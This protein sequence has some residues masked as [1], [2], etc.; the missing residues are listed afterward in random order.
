MIFLVQFGVNKHLLIFAKTTNCTRPTGS[1][2]FVSLWKNLLISLFIYLFAYLFQ[3]ALEIMWLPIQIVISKY[4]P[5]SAF[6]MHM[7]SAPVKI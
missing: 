4:T 1:C 6:S 5:T 3:I 7:K 2:N